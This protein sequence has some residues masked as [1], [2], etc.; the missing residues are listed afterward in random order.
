MKTGL[1]TD[2]VDGTSLFALL[3]TLLWLALVI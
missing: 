1:V 2:S 3:A